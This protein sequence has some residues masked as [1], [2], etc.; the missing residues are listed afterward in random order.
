M[1]N[2]NLFKI[3]VFM[4]GFLLTFTL[5]FTEIPLSETCT[6]LYTAMLNIQKVCIIPTQDI[7]FSLRVHS[8]FRQQYLPMFPTSSLH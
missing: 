7:H 3:L 5:G 6:P 2:M 1:Q 4:L 8:C